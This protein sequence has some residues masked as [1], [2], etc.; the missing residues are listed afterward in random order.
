[1]SLMGLSGGAVRPPLS[2]LTDVVQDGLVQ[3]MHTLGYVEPLEVA[4]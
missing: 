3:L 2:E 1:M 4:R